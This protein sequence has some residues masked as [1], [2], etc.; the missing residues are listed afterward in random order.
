[1]TE[2]VR[3]CEC[4]QIGLRHWVHNAH[5][6]ACHDKIELLMSL[7]EIW[8]EVETLKKAKKIAAALCTFGCCIK[9][10]INVTINK[11]RGDIK[12]I[13]LA[14]P[15]LYSFEENLKKKFVFSVNHTCVKKCKMNTKADL[16]IVCFL[17][18][19]LTKLNAF[20]KE[21]NVYKN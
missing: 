4:E 1:M 6:L 9:N 15:S 11:R 19:F 14:S 12:Y 18:L 13:R 17:L 3:V 16:L 2:F 21:K 7:L 10:L 20:T 8:K 5:P